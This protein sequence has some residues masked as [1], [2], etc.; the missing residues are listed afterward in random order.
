M[1]ILRIGANLTQN[2][3]KHVFSGTTGGRTPEAPLP[4][5]TPRNSVPDAP[6]QIILMPPLVVGAF[7][8]NPPLM[9]SR[10]VGTQMLARTW[11]TLFNHSYP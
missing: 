1:N 3:V 5:G 4:W 10:G 9:V 8:T 6:K 2:V 7:Q 11:F